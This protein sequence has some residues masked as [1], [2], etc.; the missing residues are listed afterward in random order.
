MSLFGNLSSNISFP[1]FYCLLLVLWI[2]VFGFNLWCGS[3]SEPRYRQLG[4]TWARAR[5]LRLWSPAGFVSEIPLR[6]WTCGWVF[7][8]NPQPSSSALVWM[9]AGD[10]DWHRQVTFPHLPCQE[11]S[12]WTSP[13]GSAGRRLG[14]FRQRTAGVAVL[15]PPSGGSPSAA[16][17]F[18]WL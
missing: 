14:G 7:P 12:S 10:G 11:D 18:P 15:P 17:H 4:L 3:W 8:S 2:N 5:R 9:R 13:M 6:G 1:S 16:A